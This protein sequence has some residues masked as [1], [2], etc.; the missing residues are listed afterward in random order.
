MQAQFLGRTCRQFRS[1]AMRSVLAALHLSMFATL[2]PTHAVA[3]P[4]LSTRYSQNCAGCH[5]PGRKN[6]PSA[7]RRCSLNCQGC[8]VNPSGGGLRSQYGKWNEER[9]LKSF[10]TDFLANP[11]STA[12][13]KAQ[14]YAKADWQKSSKLA[15]QEGYPLVETDKIDPDEAD[16][17]KRDKM[18][19]QTAETAREFLFQ[20][21]QGDPYRQ[22]EDNKIDGGGDVRWHIR[23]GTVTNVAVDGTS[24]VANRNPSFLMNADIGLRLRP[25]HR[26][27]NIV[28]EGRYLGNPAPDD[29]KRPSDIGATAIRRSLYVMVDELPYSVYVMAG[30]YRP[31]FGYMTP[32]HTSLEQRMFSQAVQGN[33]RAYNI[34]FESF[35]VG[36]S[37]NLPFFNVHIITNQFGG[38]D[39]DVRTKGLA[40]NFGIRFVSFG[41]S[42]TYSYWRTTGNLAVGNDDVISQLE[43]HSV[44]MG[45]QLGRATINASFVSYAKDVP[46][47]DFRQGGTTSL[48]SLFRVWRENYLIAQYA[49]SNRAEDLSPGS[50]NQTRYGART[51]LT[52]GIELSAYS[53]KDNQTKTDTD[54]SS[55]QTSSVADSLNLQIHGYF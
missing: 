19:F 47:R 23:K 52:S 2:L 33:N 6:V 12:P 26:R 8:H 13:Y 29:K 54:D 31:A 3:E 28:Y 41:A 10:R 16:Y 44:G 4:W 15:L 1:L 17:D 27:V 32:D 20:L 5:A 50:G 9:W 35:S 51:F 14:R 45:G 49:T 38:A 53:E 7:Y 21:P 22:M 40:A 30:Y 18:E 42:L 39:P 37:P 55:K 34:S 46:K 25:T 48:D 36:G 24:E 43:M 11:K